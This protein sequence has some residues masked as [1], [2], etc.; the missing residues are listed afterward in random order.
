VAYGAPKPASMNAT[1]VQLRPFRAD[2]LDVITELGLRSWEPA[3]DA[4]RTILGKRI[5]ELAYPDWS[6]TQAAQIRETITA[7]EEQTIVAELN[8]HVV[9]FAVVVIHD[10]RTL[11]P[12][13]GELEMIAVDPD[14]QRHGVGRSLV[15]AALHIMRDSRCALARVS[16]GGDPGHAP[17]RALYETVGFAPLPITTYYLDL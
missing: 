11:T 2:D 16:T 17:A 3:Y 6:I 7:H 8:G 4:W 1:T 9:G 12:K 5:Y 14:V 15:D 13:T 10:P